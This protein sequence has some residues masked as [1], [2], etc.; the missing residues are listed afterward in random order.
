[1]HALIA[2]RAAAAA[3]LLLTGCFYVDPIVARPVVRIV[4]PS[5]IYRGGNA[6]LTAGFSDPSAA[7]GTYEWKIYACTDYRASAGAS[8]CDPEG[9]ELYVPPDN[10]RDTVQFQVQ[11]MTLSGAGLTRGIQVQL[12]ARS[13]R[14][15]IAEQT[16]LTEF[17]V[18]D[19]PPELELDA[20][21]R[22]LAAGAPIDVAV[23]VPIELSARYSDPD[24]SLDDIVL[25][26]EPVPP[27]T[28]GK[29]TFEDLPATPSSD[30]PDPKART[31]RKRLVPGEPGAW[32]V[33]VTAHYRP[34]I[35]PDLSVLQHK[36]FMVH[37]DRPPCLAQWQPI[38]PPSGTTLPLSAPT[39][40]QVPLVQ[41]DLDAYPPVLDAPQYGMSTFAWSILPPRASQRQ[42]LV[43]ATGNR[44]DFDPGAFRLGDIV[45]LR[46]E[47]FDRHPTAIPCDDGAAT[48]SI[49][50]S[51]DCIQRQTWRVEVR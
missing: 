29:F 9:E 17:P 31:V 2:V 49:T 30:A 24:N 40:F 26:W 42:I 28:P 51:P 4:A 38:A 35:S 48:C 46:V 39:V 12:V 47:V 27:S 41:D 13:S 33:K 11:A 25:D 23:G 21:A 37:P 7:P 16:G 34:G 3:G 8:G 20:W 18:S 10:L 43:G 45:E 44:I 32:D 5:V 1:M 19:A 36:P 50:G 14:G 15:A 6:M 22:G